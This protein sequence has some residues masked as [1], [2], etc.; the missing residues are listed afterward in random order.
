[1]AADS[2]H[3]VKQ[4]VFGRTFF[5]KLLR[6]IRQEKQAQV[7]KKIDKR[8]V[9][10]SFCVCSDW[11]CGRFQS[12]RRYPNLTHFAKGITGLRWRS[13]S[14]HAVISKVCH[15]KYTCYPVS[16]TLSCYLQFSMMSFQ[17]DSESAPQSSSY[18]VYTANW[19]PSLISR[20]IP[21]P[22]LKSW[23]VF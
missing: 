23:T 15:S 18:L 11:I 22:R 17:G 13:G 19:L 6:Y 9:K 21:M 5:P 8:Q 20:F 2:L 16:D 7:L 4:G 12:M 10:G 3:W 14:D 1:M